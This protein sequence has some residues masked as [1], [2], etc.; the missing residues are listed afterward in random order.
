M[1]TNILSTVALLS[2]I[3]LCASLPIPDI[4][5]YHTA[6]AETNTQTETQTVTT[7]IPVVEVLISNGVTYTNTLTT[8]ASMNTDDGYVTA[9]LTSTINDATTSS[10]QATNAPIVV[11]VPPGG[12]SDSISG[13]INMLKTTPVS[14]NTVAQTTVSAPA[15][16]SSSSEV[17]DSDTSK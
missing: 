2:L 16:S 10:S 7:S 4:T 1:N 14:V 6:E 12:T 9:T 11:Y 17:V 3:Q 13:H 5:R 15:A 8:L